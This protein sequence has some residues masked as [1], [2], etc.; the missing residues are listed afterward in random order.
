M[1][2]H[3]RCRCHG[4]ESAIWLAKLWVLCSHIFSSA[5]S[6]YCSLFSLFF[7]A[8]CLISTIIVISFISIDIVSFIFLTTLYPLLPILSV[9]SVPAIF[10]TITLFI[11]LLISISISILISFSNPIPIPI[12]I[13][14]LNFNR[15][16]VVPSEQYLELLLIH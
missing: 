7:R 1:I 14:S 15:F 6:W 10:Y 12:F 2:L 5:S 9:F 11:F 16:L 13:S 3:A 4:F 8:R